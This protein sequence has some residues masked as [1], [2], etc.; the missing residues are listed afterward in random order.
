MFSYAIYEEQTHLA[1]LELSAFVRAVAAVFGP[2][3]ARAATEDWLDEADAV[4]GPPLFPSAEIGG[5]SQSLLQHAYRYR[6][7]LS[8]PKATLRYRPYHRL[9][10]C[11][12]LI[13]SD[14]YIRSQHLEEE[15]HTQHAKSRTPK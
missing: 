7:T 10:V 6:S 8:Q 9:I 12:L 14:A 2:D 3:Q 1:E 5:Q 11:R 15:W 13:W 4:D